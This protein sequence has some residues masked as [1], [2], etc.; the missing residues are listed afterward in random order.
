M[1]YLFAIL[2]VASA[3]WADCESE[4]PPL[5]TA[6]A[7]WSPSCNPWSS[8]TCVDCRFRCQDCCDDEYPATGEPGEGCLAEWM[9]CVHECY[10]LQ[11]QCEGLPANEAWWR[12]GN[13]GAD[14]IMQHAGG[15]FSDF[16][17]HGRWTG[18]LLRWPGRRGKSVP[19]HVPPVPAIDR[20]L[21]SDILGSVTTA[22]L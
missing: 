5:V 16:C 4:I 9:D 11:S 21:Q 17:S 3:A 18:R 2:L 6:Q 1:R 15:F 14:V 8:P 10:V 12:L 20:S 13:Q 19:T 22:S 7:C